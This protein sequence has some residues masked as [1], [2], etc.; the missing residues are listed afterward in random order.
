MILLEKW[1]LKNRILFYTSLELNGA[2]PLTYYFSVL[3][4]FLC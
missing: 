4:R 2:L 1:Y 3:I